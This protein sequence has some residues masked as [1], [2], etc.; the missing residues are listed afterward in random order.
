MKKKFKKGDAVTISGYLDPHLVVFLDSVSR[1]EAIGALV[2]SLSALGKLHDKESF[3]R[4]ILER[5]KIVS[6][7]IGLSVAI[8]HAKLKNYPDFFIAVGIQKKTGIEWNALDNA[9]VHLVFLIGGPENRQTEYLKILSHL[10]LAIKN[11]ERRK[12]LLQAKTPGYRLNHQY[13]FNRNEIENWMIRCRLKAAGDGFSPFG[14]K[15][16]D[17]LEE[18]PQETEGGSARGGVRQFGLYRAIHQGEVFNHVK[19][20][21]KDDLICSTTREIAPKLGVDAEVLSELLLDRERLMPTAL[22]NGIAVPHT[23]DFLM[24]GPFDSVVLVF[25]QE[26]IEYGALDGKPVHALF[27]L[28]ACSDKRHLHLLAKI[29][30]LCSNPAALELLRTQPDKKKTLEFIR[31]WETSLRHQ[32]E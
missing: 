21:N 17:P 5:E 27:F 29:A 1:D 12:K 13:R 26:P 18:M 24:K 15:T 20:K 14:E 4:A 9:P 7:G 23:R 25:P 16:G 3:Y 8:P 11:E 28:F 2:D 30:H 6:T 32:G 22:N 10:T 31:H 19:D